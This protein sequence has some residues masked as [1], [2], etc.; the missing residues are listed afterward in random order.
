MMVTAIPSCL[1]CEAELGRLPRRCRD[2]CAT[3][4]QPRQ[5]SMVCPSLGIFFWR[6]SIECEQEVFLIYLYCTPAY[7]QL[8]IYLISVGLMICVDGTA[9]IALRLRF[10]RCAAALCKSYLLAGWTCRNCSAFARPSL[11]QL[12][13]YFFPERWSYMTS[14]AARQHGCTPYMS[15]LAICSWS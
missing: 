1:Q 9:C 11:A 15:A 3:V 12:S 10:Y 14:F 7:S 5:E 8:W 6:K 13:L 2:R 4:Y